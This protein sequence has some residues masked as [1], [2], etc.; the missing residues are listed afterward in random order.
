MT[1][2]G[3][4]ETGQSG[5]FPKCDENREMLKIHATFGGIALMHDDLRPGD[6]T[7]KPG[8][9]GMDNPSFMMMM[10]LFETRNVYKSG[11]LL[12]KFGIQIVL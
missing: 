7:P 6:R 3:R 8:K 1:L 10:I 12:R 9:A 5:V 4:P 11:Y 2:R